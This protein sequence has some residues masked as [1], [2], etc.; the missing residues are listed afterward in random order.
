[1]RR[2]VLTAGLLGLL[3]AAGCQ[4]PP[5]PWE[6][7]MPGASAA[8][9]LEAL[10]YEF[11]PTADVCPTD[12]Q[13]RE[14]FPAMT[15]FER[16]EAEVYTE[17]LDTAVTVYDSGD[18]DADS[19]HGVA[20]AVECFYWIDDA[21][22]VN[23]VFSVYPFAEDAADAYAD[24]AQGE[25]HRSPEWDR[26]SYALAAAESDAFSDSWFAGL[27]GQVVVT[28]GGAIAVGGLTKEETAAAMFALASVNADPLWE[29]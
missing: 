15:G 1:M 4:S 13:V 23:V 14:A 6:S 5:A 22:F 11:H 20:S 24:R 7:E 9:Y 2:F 28:G 27:S 21:D 8:E 10:S 29:R 3:A 12:A 26:A 17:A 18:A 25:E 19:L 16:T